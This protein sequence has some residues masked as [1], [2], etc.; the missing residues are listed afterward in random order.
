MR[1]QEAHWALTLQ[2]PALPVLQADPSPPA[3]VSFLS[4]SVPYAEELR[5]ECK[6][7]TMLERK[8]NI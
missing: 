1:P 6:S 8:E 4:Y 2:C 3:A 7:Y 5:F